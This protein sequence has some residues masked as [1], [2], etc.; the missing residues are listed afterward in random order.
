MEDNVNKGL[1]RAV[2]L[3]QFALMVNSQDYIPIQSISHQKMGIKMKK[4]RTTHGLIATI[5]MARPKNVE[6]KT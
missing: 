1:S 5:V 6:Q 3:I 4:F 2:I